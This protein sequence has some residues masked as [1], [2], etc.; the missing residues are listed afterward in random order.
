MR[1]AIADVYD[2][3]MDYVSNDFI[4]EHLEEIKKIAEGD[5]A[6]IEGLRAALAE[7]IFVNIT[8][9]SELKDG[10]T[11]E[12][13]LN[14]FRSLR[15][16][17]EAEMSG[18]TI[19]DD[20]SVDDTKLV[21]DLNKLI[22]DCQMTVE[23]ANAVF[24]AMGVEPTYETE[25]VTQEQSNP[26][27]QT[28]T[29]TTETEPREVEYIGP[30]GE[31]HTA[32]VP[33][34]TQ[35]QTSRTIGYS[36]DNVE[37]PVTAIAVNGK[38][39]KISGIKKAPGGSMNNYSSQNK[40]GKVPGSKSS[41]GKGGGS[42]AKEPAEEKKVE[43]KKDPYHDIDIIIK[44][45]S[46]D[47]DKLQKQQSKFFGQ[48]LIDN[49]NKQYELLNKQIDATT[50]KLGI[51]RQEQARLASELSDRGVRFNADGTIAN[52]AQAYDAQLSYVNGIINQYN[53][54][55]AEEQEG[56][57]KTLE[58]AKEG[59]DK[60]TEAISEY[61]KTVTDTIPE[62]E[63]NI[64]DAIDKQIEIK[65]EEFTMEIKIRLDM[66]EAERD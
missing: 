18:L 22:K 66:S 23:Q 65:I 49:L 2:T 8:A 13:I 3:S 56:F 35:I 6:A 38:Q 4:K 25:T 9:E 7:E 29:Q 45:I 5:E 53:A 26:I 34:F 15:S 21:T 11:R 52:Y 54:M 31:K 39:P 10:V 63:S 16:Q 47:L 1:D 59:F 33:N 30:D 20:I 62:L 28:D 48:R 41:G 44:D 24:S 40:G 61:D 17:I 42:K 12:E 64:Q 14:T 60:F 32:K 19:G 37:V 50:Q 51:A 58:E 46:H 27:I 55:T 36:K 43:S 57:K